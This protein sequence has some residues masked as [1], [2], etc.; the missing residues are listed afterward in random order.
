MLKH[1]RRTEGRRRVGSNPHTSDWT[2]PPDITE[3]QNS[4]EWNTTEYNI[5]GEAIQG[6]C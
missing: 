6:E 1:N 4:L 5:Q 2:V 3:E